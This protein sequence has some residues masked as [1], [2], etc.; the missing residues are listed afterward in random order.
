MSVE[1]TITPQIEPDHISLLDKQVK[2]LDYLLDN[3]HSG[4]KPIAQTGILEQIGSLLWEASGL[5]ADG[6]LDAL[7]QARDDE[8]PVRLI[9]AGEAFH[10]LPWELL[11]SP[12][13]K[14][15]FVARHPWCVLARRLQG[16]GQKS[17]TL[18]PRPF[19]ILLFIASPED[20]DA[21]R[22]RLDFE[23]EEEL[24]FTALDEPLSKGELDI[25]VAE[26]GCL[27][28]LLDRLKRHQYHAIILS[29]HGTRAVKDNGK[30]EW[31]LLFEDEHTGRSAP[32]AGSD[33]ATQLD[34]LPSGHRPGLVVLSACRSAKAE[35]SADSITSVAT[36]LHEGGFERVL[37]MRL[38]V[39]DS[40]ASAFNAQLFP[41]LAQGEAVGRAVTLARDS[42]G[43]GGWL[44]SG[45]TAAKGLAVGDV[46]A[47]WTL[48]VLFDRTADGPLVDINAPVQIEQRP[49]LPTVLAG[50]GSI[51]L[52][53]RDT[54]VG[55][56]AFIRQ[57]LRPFLEGKTRGL[58]LTG[59]GGVG[60]TALAG[61]FA[62]RL[63]ERQADIRILG[64]R[65]PFELDMLYEP[66]RRE[67]CD[68]N[69]DPALVGRIQIETD[70]KEQ[71]RLIL[72]SFAQRKRPCAFVLDNLESLQELETLETSAE[73]ADSLWLLQTVCALPAPTRLVLTGRYP[74]SELSKE[75]VQQS[76][77]LD[78]PYGDVLRR[79]RGL[80]WP[81]EMTSAEKREVYTV[82]GGNHRAIEWTAQLLTNQ[83]QK[84]HELL[85]ALAQ[86]EAP[87]ETPRTAVDVVAEAMR[88]NLLFD[89][90]R[91]QL[92]PVQ[93]RLLR[94][95]CLYRV[96]VNADGLLALEPQADQAEHNCERLVTYALL[97]QATDP[98]F[99]L[100]YFVVPPIV[101]ELL[102]EPSF[103]AVERQ[104]L[105]RAMGQHHRFQGQYVS[106][107]WSD[108]IEAIYH[109]RQAEEHVDADQ[110]AERVC[111]FYYRISNY[112]DASLL[113]AE[114]VDRDIPPAP[115]WALNRYGM[116]QLTLGFPAGALTAFEQAL[117]LAPNEE[118]KGTTL[119]NLSQIYGARGDYDTA[120]RYL[121]QSLQIRR[122]IGDKAGEGTT[123]NNLSQIYKTR[124]DYDTALRYLEQ[125]LA[126]YRDIGDKAGEGTTLNNLSQIYKARG[127]Y[128]TALRYL[129][130]SLQIQR[131][132]GDKAGEGTTLNNLS[133]TAYARG[134]YDT[135]LRYLEQSLQ[136]QRDIG[137]KAGEGTTLNNLSQIYGARGDYDTALRY[138]EQSLQIQRDIGDKAG[139]IPTLHNMAQIAFQAEDTKRAME[140]WSEA[141]SFALE[142]K[143]AQG[144]FHVASTLGTILARS[145]HDQAQQLLQMAVDVGKQ[146]S[147][148]EVE[149]VEAT[150]SQLQAK[151]K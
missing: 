4:P 105:H 108:D 49:A 50:D 143:N 18:L 45:E 70:R 110:L 85:G 47:Q 100:D 93:D 136:I 147:F 122:D 38:V 126:I 131:D 48:P 87:P 53:T 138:L 99:Q 82:L 20:L 27:N 140:L 8:K 19:R 40:A 63:S 139:M 90:L 6:L 39:L 25:D 119:N 92:T 56:R 97:E 5:Q 72:Q 29:L 7:E 67:A 44:S 14:L 24:L 43:Q 80:D 125:S 71:I 36:Q 77:V 151:A 54:F 135:A 32:V 84:S 86:L 33:L 134:D 65:A 149:Q 114:I 57:Y 55:R 9:V 116:C 46:F 128:D 150:L 73:Y 76:P 34:R 115:W 60:K 61:L 124:G 26:D 104:A 62:R 98:V 133:T 68:N 12:H 81:A 137:D 75:V 37:G 2:Q 52:P 145:G 130:Q 96:P 15:G 16:K 11:Y 129:E 23:K 83:Q 31:G 103:E 64:F 79:M 66:L 106:K 51:H 35:E 101:Q 123:L 118:E 102:G 28:T 132:I 95:A 142:T 117:P 121:E 112:T 13:E 1:I 111:G 120:L 146:A 3:P 21:E 107:R 113:T 59:P 58:M 74:F 69:E 141:L 41:L 88:Q 91:E 78:A 89:R 10:H 109:F 144:I 94:T 30:K 127:D 17:P 42:V 22:S 148:P